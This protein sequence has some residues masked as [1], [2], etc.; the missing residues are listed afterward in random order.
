[1]TKDDIEAFKK[2]WVASVKRALAAG[3][4]VIEIHNAQYVTI[5][6]CLI[7]VVLTS[8]SGYLLHSF[9]SHASNQRTDEYG[10]SF[11]NRTR[12][13]R[14]V[15]DLTRETI[16]DDMPLFLRISAT[17]WLDGVEGIE[18]WKIEDTIRLAEIVAEKGVDLLDVST[19]GNHPKQQIKTG[20]GYQ[21]VCVIVLHITFLLN[22]CVAV[23]QGRQGEGR[24]QAGCW[25]R[26]QHHRW[27]TSE[28]ATRRRA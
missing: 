1:M 13:T 17:D 20:P 25:C 26:R 6:R 14:E 3:F 28:S 18:G 15:V 27:Q 5:W 4:D 11:E 19:G 16:P 7:Q 2:A 10:G 12:L 24:R 21:S 8:S 22:L 9:I 23:F